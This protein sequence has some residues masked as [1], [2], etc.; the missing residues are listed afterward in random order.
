MLYI[1]LKTFE[2][3]AETH[4]LQRCATFQMCYIYLFNMCKKCNYIVNVINCIILILLILH[5]KDYSERSR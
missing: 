4:L 1:K 5:I 2:K 3:I